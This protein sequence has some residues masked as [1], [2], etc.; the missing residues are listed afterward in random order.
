MATAAG[1]P[2]ESKMSVESDHE[3]MPGLE[4]LERMVA[5]WHASGMSETL[6]M[7][8]VAVAS[9]SATFT[10]RATPAAAPP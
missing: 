5:D 3:N 9:G 7:R 6:G 8:L 10:A 2:G 1:S 4:F